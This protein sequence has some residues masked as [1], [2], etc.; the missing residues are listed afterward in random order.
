LRHP[1]QDGADRLPPHR[2]LCIRIPRS[3]VFIHAG[4]MT[5]SSAKCKLFND[6]ISS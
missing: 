4:S 5:T 1:V 2:F 6:R 3:C